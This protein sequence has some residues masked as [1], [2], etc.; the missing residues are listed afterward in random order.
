MQYDSVIFIN[1]RE[2][3]LDKPA[4]FIADIASNHDGKLERAKNL[5]RIAKNAGADAVKFQH[6]KASKI[7][8]D[9][10]FKNLGGQISHQSSWK[11][12]VFEVYKQYECNREWIA[13]L[14]NVAK[15]AGIDFMT[16]PYDEEAITLL[17]NYLPAYKIGSGDITWTDFIEMVARKGKPVLLA[18]GASRMEDVIR[19]VNVVIKHN[20]QIVLL[21][22]NTNY[23]GS[24]DNFRHINL[25]VLRTFAI[26]F[27]NMLLGLSDHTP[28][29]SSVLGAISLGARVI[30]KHFTDDNTREGPDHAFSMNPKTWHEMIERSRELELSLGDGI[31]IIEENETDTVVLQRRC[32][33][34]IRDVKAGDKINSEDLEALRPAP[35]NSV[36]PFKLIDMA[37]KLLSVSK[38][39]GDA[40]YYSDVKEPL[41]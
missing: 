37:G 5:I 24:I 21:Q 36:P 41:C 33:R 2:I 6:F 11:K 29:H 32:L 26:A 27:P 22:C 31:K 28:G 3:A 14:A 10:G 23:T 1:G 25:K 8:S 39:A 4:Y 19:A 7:V 9:Y 30:E 13:E 34:F 35:F 12:S 38:V 20:R 18:T 17:D 40:L 16:T 15:E